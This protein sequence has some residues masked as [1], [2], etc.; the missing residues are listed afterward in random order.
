[1]PS[2]VDTPSNDSVVVSLTITAVLLFMKSVGTLE[3]S[4]NNDAGTEVAK[5]DNII[6]DWSWAVSTSVADSLSVAYNNG[7]VAIE[8][9]IIRLSIDAV[10]LVALSNAVVKMA[11]VVEA[12]SK[13]PAV[14]SLTVTAVLLLEF[15]A[16]NDACIE[17]TKSDEIKP[18]CS[19]AVSTSVADNIS[20][21]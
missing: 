12:L 4:A 11:V 21:V 18:E 1:M 20:V 15:L 3:F 8:L 2:V 19:R 9:W 10:L 16:S 14:L 7:V 13:D 6:P 5:S 17:V